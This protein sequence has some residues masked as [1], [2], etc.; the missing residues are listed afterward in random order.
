MRSFLRPFLAALVLASAFAA[1][2][3]AGDLCGFDCENMCPLAREANAWRALGS[4]A[5][6]VKSKVHEDLAARVAKN[7]GKV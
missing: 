3:A 5:V 2:A 1:P 7:L 6:A 4:E